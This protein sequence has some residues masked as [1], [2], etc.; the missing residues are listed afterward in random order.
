M[1][2]LFDTDKAEM[3]RTNL[4]DLLKARQKEDAN[5]EELNEQARTHLE[6]FLE[7]EVKNETIH[8]YV[9]MGEPEFI[10]NRFIVMTG[11]QFSENEAFYQIPL[12][13]TD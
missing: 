5:I 1:K 11:V 13:V 6:E 10:E 7:E 12:E 3:L 9:I 2:K 4:L 8:N